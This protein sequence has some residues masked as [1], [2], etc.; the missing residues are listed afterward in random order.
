MA[1]VVQR[2]KKKKKWGHTWVDGDEKR[3]YLGT[4]PRTKEHVQELKNECGIGGIVTLNQRWEL[5]LTK[6][7]IEGMGVKNIMLYVGSLA[8]RRSSS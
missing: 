2:C 3:I 5:V 4:K 8:T 7:E 6:E 1:K